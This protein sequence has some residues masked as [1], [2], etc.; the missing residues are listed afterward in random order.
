MTGNFDNKKIEIKC[1]QCQRK[2]RKSVKDLKRPG[3]KCPHCSSPF[4]TSQFKREVDK[5]DRSLKDFERS[6]KSINI[7]L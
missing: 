3:F 2:I 4:N 1:P 5:A 7:K 6:L